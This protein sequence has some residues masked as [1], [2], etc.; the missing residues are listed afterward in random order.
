M[1]ENYYFKDNKFRIFVIGK[2]LAKFFIF[3]KDKNIT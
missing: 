2:D 3:I 1:K